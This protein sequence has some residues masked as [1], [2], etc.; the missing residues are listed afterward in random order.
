MTKDMPD[1]LKNFKPYVPASQNMQEFSMRAI[2]LGSVLGIVFGAANVYLGMKVGMT[3]CASIPAAVMSMAI[4]RGVMKGGTILENNIV[5]TIASAGESLAAGVIFTIP[6]FLVMRYLL[7]WDGIPESQLP[8]LP[9]MT[10]VFIMTLIG[11]LLGTLMMIPLR[12]Y[13]IVKEHGELPYPEGM[14][15][16]QVLE[17][18]DTGGTQ[19]KHVFSGLGFGAL[20]MFL[21]KGLKL[22]KDEAMWVIPKYGKGAIGLEPTA[23]LLGVGFIIGPKIAAYMFAGGMLGWLV[24]IPIFGM[25]GEFAP[26][27]IIAPGQIPISEMSSGAIASSYIRYIGAGGVALGGIVSL[28]KA[29]PVIISSF[30]HGLKGL[31]GSIRKKKSE[32]EILR[33]DRDMP[34]SFVFGGSLVLALSIAL[35]LYV[36]ASG[37]GWSKGLGSLSLIGGCVSILF[38]FFFVTVAARVVGIVGSSSS[39]VSGMTITTLLAVCLVL[40]LSGLT[41]GANQIPAMVIALSAGAMVCIA[42]CSS[43]DIS[44][45]LKTG[46]LV[47][48]TPSKQQ[49][50]E[51][52]AVIIP[53]ITIVG[54][55]YL[56]LLRGGGLNTL[57]VYEGKVDFMKDPIVSISKEKKE[58]VFET[59][60]YGNVPAGLSVIKLKNGKVYEGKVTSHGSESLYF[61][62][63]KLGYVRFDTKEIENVRNYQDPMGELRAP[64][65]NIMAILVKGIIQKK[66]PW[67]LIFLGIVIGLVIELLGISSLPFAI[68]LY[69]GIAMNVPIVIGGTIYAILSR[70]IRPSAWKDAEHRGILFSSGVIAGD[71]LMGIGLVLLAMF[72]I[73][74]HFA[75]RVIGGSHA[76]DLITLA[77]FLGFTALFVY[78]VA[79]KDKKQAA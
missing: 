49:I 26:G 54:T 44:Q 66:L 2:I 12:R 32:E 15:C 69:L 36:I 19:A 61:R 16:A 30:K 42:T 4:L 22:W 79:K 58:I 41:E 43:G 39:P 57:P 29:L 47:G 20:Y 59:A 8:T 50:A 33:T 70:I 60:K 56:L 77:A 55:V 78:V 13:L 18:G 35:V 45:D 51:I 17:A 62:N 37:L 65:A 38:A 68:G 28:I 63:E 40:V 67:V 23:A 27:L 3:I 74:E 46:F 1:N 11:G 25:V 6:G 31:I 48:A 76:E 24:L 72:G 7:R 64:Q 71:A 14:A 75:L 21:M 53:S 73:S 9:S 34:A 10:L 52:I 5:Q